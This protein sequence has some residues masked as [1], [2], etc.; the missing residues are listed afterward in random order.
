MAVALLRL[1]TVTA[2]RDSAQAV[3]DQQQARA[4]SLRNILNLTRELA[5]EQSA[6]AATTRRNSMMRNL[7]VTACWTALLAALA[8]C[9]STQPA[10]EM[11]SPTP[12]EP[13]LMQEPRDLLPLL[14]GIIQPYA[15]DSP[16]NERK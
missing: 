12:L 2:Q 4:D 10:C 7:S 5:E 16:S 13:A 11:G 14:N 3:A 9:A 1:D 15:R 6:I 8:G